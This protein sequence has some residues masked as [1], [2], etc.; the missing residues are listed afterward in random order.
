VGD[1]LELRNVPADIIRRY[2]LDE[3]DGT[4]GRDGAVRGDGWVVRFREGDAVRIPPATDVPVLF[5][6]VE[7]R[8]ERRVTAFVMRKSLRGGG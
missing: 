5:V 7:G 1:P 3:L 4:A 8:D 6:D 2:L